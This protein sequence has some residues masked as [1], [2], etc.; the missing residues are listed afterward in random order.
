VALFY[1]GSIIG[2]AKNPGLYNQSSPT[3]VG[4]GGGNDMWG[5]ALTPAIVND[6][7]FG[8]GFQVTIVD[9]GTTRSFF[10]YFS[11]TVSYFVG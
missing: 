4:F 10:Y 1:Q 2:T 3:V 5:A 6:S 7:S 9:N 11:V 8:V